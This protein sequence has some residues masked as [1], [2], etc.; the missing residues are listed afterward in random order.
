MVS[1]GDIYECS[2][3]KKADLFWQTFG[4]MGLTG[5]ILDV[6]FRLKKIET[7]LIRMESIKTRNF[8]EAMEVFEKSESWTYSVAW[9]DCLAKGKS[10]GR[11]IVMRGEHAKKED[12]SQKQVQLKFINK[13]KINVPFHFPA[14]TLNKFSVRAFNG[15]YYGKQRNRIKTLLQDY[16]SFFYPLDFVN[17]WNRIYGKNGFTQYQCAIP[18]KNSEAG[19]KELLESLVQNGKG[20]FLAVLKR[21]GQKDIHAV[22]SFPVEGYTLALDF[23]IDG[24]IKDLLRKLDEIVMKYDGRLYLAK[25]SMCSNFDLVSYTRNATSYFD[26]KFCSLQSSRIDQLKQLN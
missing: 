21:F 15:M 7:T 8:L 4:A 13:T 18:L 19:L 9:I 10:L 2:P 26:E 25:D 22:N 20:S 6:T 17:N 14:I 11:S 5:I 16:D 24:G 23:K 1:N 3:T 12:V